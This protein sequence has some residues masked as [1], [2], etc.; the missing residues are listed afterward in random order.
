[1]SIS[2]T[3]VPWLYKMLTLGQLGEGHMGTLHYHCNFSINLKLPKDL[4]ILL[5]QCKSEHVIPLLHVC[6]AFQ[7][8]CACCISP[9]SPA[10]LSAPKRQGCCL[11]NCCRAQHSQAHKGSLKA[12]MFLQMSFLPPVKLLTYINLKNSDSFVKTLF[13][14]PFLYGA[15]NDFPRQRQLFLQHFLHPFNT[16]L[17]SHCSC[18]FALL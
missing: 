3:N 13:K 9:F 17:V 5:K 1:M 12:I 7:C 8:V 2:Q 16:S 10:S 15:C 14:C 18:F 6:N 4:K 11:T